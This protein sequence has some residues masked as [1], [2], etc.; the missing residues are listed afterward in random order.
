MDLKGRLI[1]GVG[2]LV[3]I[4]VILYVAGVWLG[5]SGPAPVNAN[6]TLD[7]TF[8]LADFT[9]GPQAWVPYASRL[10]VVPGSAM[11]SNNNFTIAF[12]DLNVS[13]RGN[14]SLN[15]P[16]AI[17]YSFTGLRGVAAFHVYGYNGGQGISWT[18]RVE[19]DGTSGF[20]VIGGAATPLSSTTISPVDNHMTFLA[21]NYDNTDMANSSYLL[22]FNKQGGGLNALRL[23]TD[24]ATGGQP[25]FT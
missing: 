24:P 5:D 7:R 15:V 13:S 8:H 11:D 22:N 21:A 20:Y 23:S 6:R 1:A 19:G 17:D 14:G 2:V 10:Q 3:I 16:V 25:F 18:N 12:I 4:I 9:Y